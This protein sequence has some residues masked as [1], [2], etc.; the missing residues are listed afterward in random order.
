M[1]G[2]IILNGNRPDIALDDGTLYGGLHCGDCFRYYDGK[3]IDVRLE[4][5]DDWVFVHNQAYQK[6]IYG[7]QVII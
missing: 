5:K 3:W 2:M 4:Y 1:F 6:I 7:K